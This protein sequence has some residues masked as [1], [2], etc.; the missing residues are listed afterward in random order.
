MA[1]FGSVLGNGFTNYDDTDYVVRNPAVR[2]G[3]TWAGARWAFTTGWASN[4]HPL[5]WLSHM[6]DVTLF[7]MNPAGHHATNLLLH[8][9]NTVLLFLFLE[10]L[11][12]RSMRSA[13][14]AALFAVHPAHVQSVAWV[15]ERKDVLSTLFWL[16]TSWAYVAW[17]RRKSFSRYLRVLLFFAAGLMSKPMLVSLPVVLLLLDVWPLGRLGAEARARPGVAASRLQLLVEKAPLF[18]MAA[19]A[20]VVT[21]FVQQA[22]GAVRSIEKIPFDGRLENA[23]VS[24]VRYL[25]ML[26]WP[27]RLAVFY[28]HPGTSLPTSAVV[29]AALMLAAICAAVVV[30]RRRAP[31][32]F[33]G[34]GW[35]LVTLLPVI[36][37]IQ[38]GDQAMADRYTYVPFIG[39]FIAI[40]WGASELS[41]G[42]RVPR[43]AFSAAGAVAVLALAA[44]SYLE[45]RHWRSSETL[46]LHA[47][48]ATKDNP[49][50][51][52][53]LAEYYNGLE[54]PAEALPH[55]LEAARIR[56]NEPSAFVNVGHSYFLLNRLDEAERYFRSG[57]RID[58]GNAIASN[59]LARV[60][61]VRGDIPG[62]IRLYT[63]A[64]AGSPLWSEP[65]RRLA[66]ARLMVGQTAA[67]EADLETAVRIDPSDREAR[68]LLEGVRA[69][70]RSPDDSAALQFRRYLTSAHLEMYT[71][72]DR[73]GNPAE[74]KSHVERAL[75]LSP[76]SAPAHIDRGALLVGERRLAEAAAEF[77]R[78]L[79]LDPRS[80]LAHS[81]L[82]YVLFLGGRKEEAIAHYR[83]ALRLDPALDL[84]RNNLELALR[85]GAPAAAGSSERR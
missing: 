77:E 74:A 6:A 34:W 55:A 38:V 16:A 14:V 35:F 66:V 73:L 2:A 48:E 43:P 52:N 85:D 79:V 78:A 1:T 65:S 37:L 83:E 29:G 11:T 46:F 49:V 17:V 4:W 8:L 10:N 50:A 75:V 24:A 25:K 30:L 26:F 23:L 28:P 63:A 72:L 33:V 81:N 15:A 61:F 40:A 71:A 68:M 67:A 3:L 21:F 41:S 59:D 76:D 45:V 32:L 62:A 58:P 7:G 18:L 82:G 51:H 60:H 13:F 53:N 39:L 22:G 44:A 69:F 19:T 47:I 42:L 54:R 9:I 64:V 27:S 70:E 80:A 5:T 56:P 20:S 31:Y 84:A 12:G 57:L 36:G